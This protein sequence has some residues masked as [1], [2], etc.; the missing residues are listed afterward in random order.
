[1]ISAKSYIKATS[2]D[3][4]I[5]L[6][7]KHAGIFRYIAGGTD[8]MVNKFQGNDDAS[9]LIDISEIAELKEIYVTENFLL[10]GALVCLDDLKKHRFIARN[11]PM[12]IEAANSVASPT[13]RKTATIGGNLLCENRCLFYNQS[14]LWREA[15]GSCLKCNGKIC[16]ASGGKKSCYSKCVSD[17]AIA[18][19]SVNAQ[20][21]VFD[22]EDISLKPLES[23]Y[24][25]DGIHPR[26]LKMTA[27]LS[28]ISIPRNE[29]LRSVFK[30][31]R[32]RETLDFTSLTTAVSLT[33]TGKIRIVLGGVHAKPVIVDG[34]TG[35]D[36]N[37][38]ISE[39]ISNTRIV[40]ND[41]YSRAYRKE[42]IAV[43]LNQ[44]FKE[45]QLI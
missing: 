12:L 20:I 16:L 34:F 42:M 11:F 37:L 17:T 22:S 9:L 32:K 40:D 5:S 6:A 10:I 14:E 18:L 23:I 39:A 38:L 24:T 2:M 45:L 28:S 43:F 4:A 1:M 19:I 30:K 13:I 15:A 41:T 44:S 29:N 33:K 31:L 25:G 7:E 8:V 3:N 36:L 21:H 35:N 26:D 27:I